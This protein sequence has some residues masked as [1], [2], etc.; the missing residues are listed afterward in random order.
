MPRRKHPHASGS[1]VHTSYRWTRANRTERE[2]I[3]VGEFYADDVTCFCLQLDDF[4]TWVAVAAGSGPSVWRGVGGGSGT[5]GKQLLEVKSTGNGGGVL[6]A[7][8]TLAQD[9]SQVL[10][11]A[12]GTG[13]VAPL[14]QL[15]RYGTVERTPFQQDPSGYA[16]VRECGTGRV[17]VLV[18]GSDTTIK[19]FVADEGGYALAQSVLRV[20]LTSYHGFF[21]GT[22]F[23]LAGFV[24]GAG[25]VYKFNP[26]SLASPLATITLASDSPVWVKVDTDASHYSG[27]TRGFV[28]DPVNGKVY[29]FTTGGSPAVDVT[30][31]AAVGLLAVGGGYVFTVAL[32]GGFLGTV[33]QRRLRTN[34]TVDD[35]EDLSGTF[36]AIGSVDF[37]P[38]TGKLWLTGRDGSDNLVVARVDPTTLTVES[39]ATLDS[40]GLDVDYENAPL[41]SV[42]FLD[43][44]VWV[45]DPR[46][47]IGS[48]F[49][50]AI[51]TFAFTGAL[52]ATTWPEAGSLSVG[53]AVD[54]TWTD[55]DAPMFQNAGGTAVLGDGAWS[56]RWRRIADEV[57][58][59]VQFRVSS[60]G[61][62]T[63]WGGFPPVLPMPTS[64]MPDS[65]KLGPLTTGTTPATTGTAAIVA[66]HTD[67]TAGVGVVGVFS[68]AVL[69][70]SDI[71]GVTAAGDVGSIAYR[72]PVV[73]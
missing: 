36:D 35:S 51:Y 57:E 54:S 6:G 13:A 8:I 2:A 49:D 50:P 3:V 20:G 48:G 58:V 37:E 24:G 30:V 38:T 45:V 55:L 31:T 5:A 19:R 68:G 66:N 56:A 60:A 33:L 62:S 15:D 40:D 34:L 44:R 16:L 53:A 69:L 43:E 10:T 22:S 64:Q 23:W 71:V 14:Y 32:A 18:T 52:S 70:A 42:A 7:T 46:G 4:S 1:E 11:A 72:I 47:D 17:I 41:W 12:V 63:F 21:D 28:V 73:N 67:G 26:D 39:S 27:G 29:R 59:L 61:P 65:D 9:G 25:K